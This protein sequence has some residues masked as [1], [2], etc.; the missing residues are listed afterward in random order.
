MPS[1]PIREIRELRVIA[2][3]ISV[4]LRRSGAVSITMPDRANRC[5]PERIGDIKPR[6]T[7]KLVVA[8]RT[9][10]R[11]APRELPAWES[12]IDQGPRHRTPVLALPHHSAP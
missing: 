3:Q 1:E 10:D 12:P 2:V 5:L 8:Y 6:K 7:R 11:R 9:R 4:R